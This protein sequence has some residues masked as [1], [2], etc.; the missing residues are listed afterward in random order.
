MVRFRF[1][2][3][4]LVF[5][6]VLLVPAALHAGEQVVQP[7]PATL[8][9][10]PETSVSLDVT[11]ETA[12]PRNANLTGLGL[13][14]HFDS[15]KLVFGALTNVLSKNL[16]A[17]QDPVPD[18][19]DFDADPATD[20]FILASWADFGGGWPGG[21]P[22]RLLTVG[23]T[24]S[25]RFGGSTAV[26]FSAASTAAGYKLSTKPA[27]ISAPPPLVP[28]V[29]SA[30]GL[31]EAYYTTELV[32]TNRSVSEAILTYTYTASLGGGSGTTTD[33]IP[34]GRQVV[35]HDA[36]SYL[37]SLGAPIPGEPPSLGSLSVSVAGVPTSQFSVISRTTTTVPGGRAGLAYAAVRGSALFNG[38]AW[39]CGLR[40]NSSDRSNLAVVNAGQAADGDIRLRIT[41]RSGTPSSPGVGSFDTN[42]IPPGGWQQW[43]LDQLLSAA[44][45]SL[46]DPNAFVR[47]ERIG[48]TAP[49]TAYGVVNDQGTSDGSFILPVADSSLD[50]RRSLALPVVVETSAF[51]SEL[52]VTNT[53]STR[54]TL[55]LTFVATA[56]DSIDSTATD[57]LTLEPG[58]QRI[59]PAFVA[60][61]RSRGVSGIG[62]AGPGFAGAVFVTVPGGDV[63][64]V[65]LGAR[66]S[67]LPSATGRY[68]LFYGAVPE[69]AEATRAA[70]CYGLQQNSENRSNLAFVHA[71]SVGSEPIRLRVEIFDGET[72]RLVKTIEGPETT[73]AARAWTQLNGVLGGAADGIANGYIKVSR[74]SGTSAF[75][76]YAVINDGAEPGQRSGDGAYIPMI[77]EGQ[78]E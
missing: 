73:L 32:L 57:T 35:V 53:S 36:I 24:T 70:W 15:T 39:V 71:G 29:L 18:T 67:T 69:G 62:P 37:R 30:G 1:L 14:I 19:M 75:L 11:Y 48:G 17:Q 23:F 3:H 6:V 26:R 13:R 44:G 7:E 9:R 59:I 60:Y 63:G 28:V 22:Q 74:V 12:N 5:S 76:A 25:G 52:V 61:L 8:T 46:S 72:G 65:V 47:L 68:G 2:R 56:I 78:D 41:V 66:T 55:Q 77:V 10:T 20:R 43:T 42:P 58:E 34:A 21:E 4:Q 38:A 40:A 16:L 51:T 31:G 33:R 45:V 64:G 54:K 49:Y 27:V 50:G